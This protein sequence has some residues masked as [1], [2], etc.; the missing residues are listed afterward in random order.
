MPLLTLDQ[1]SLAFGHLPLFDAADLRIEP[2]ERI[3]LIGRNGS[4][5]SSLLK[6]VSGE[7]PPDS[8]SVWRNPGLRI[9]RLEQD[10]PRAG[11][12][13]VFEEVSE[14]LRSVPHEGW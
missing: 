6:V 1:V 8:G 10:V 14:G 2:G 5:K 7:V 4:G 13:T 11:M 3:A 9:S 12:R